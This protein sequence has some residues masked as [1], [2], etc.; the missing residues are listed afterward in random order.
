MTRQE[1]INQLDTWNDTTHGAVARN[2]LRRALG[3]REGTSFGAKLAD[4]LINGNQQQTQHSTRPAS[5]EQALNLIED[6]C[7]DRTG[8]HRVANMLLKANWD[9]TDPLG[10]MQKDPDEVEDFLQSCSMEINK[11]S[12]MHPSRR[13]LF[14]MICDAYTRSLR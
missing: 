6:M 3:W 2:A 9:Y 1:I 11:W 8:V 7:F 12:E 4:A 5:T 13:N 14:K 10:M